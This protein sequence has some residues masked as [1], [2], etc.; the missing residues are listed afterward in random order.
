MGFP[1]GH[2]LVLLPLGHS[3]LCFPL[4]NLSLPLTVYKISNDCY[5]DSRDSVSMP[6]KTRVTARDALETDQEIQDGPLRH[7]TTG[8]GKKLESGRLN[9]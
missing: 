8:Q 5:L 7:P 1:P 6:L 3:L 9:Y 2:M 4:R